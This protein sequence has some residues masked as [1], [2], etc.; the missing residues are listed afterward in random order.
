MRRRR[1][2]DWDASSSVYNIVASYSSRRNDVQTYPSH[3]A[4]IYGKKFGISKIYAQ[5]GAGGFVGASHNGQKYKVTLYRY[6]DMCSIYLYY[7]IFI[8]EE[9]SI[10]LTH[11]YKD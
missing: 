10:C 1:G 3:R 5:F 7:I 4:Y 11:F 6:L 2:S 8:C 9:V